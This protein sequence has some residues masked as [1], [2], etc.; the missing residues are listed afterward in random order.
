MGKFCTKC[1]KQLAEDTKFCTSCGMA[2]D[3]SAEQAEQPEQ[4]QQ[5]NTEIGTNTASVQS[6]AA[7]VGSAAQTVKQGANLASKLLQ[8]TST[9]SSISGESAFSVPSFNSGGVMSAISP[10]T[11]LFSGAK[12]I[13]TSFKSAFKDKKKL[14]PAIVLAVTWILL[15]LLPMLGVNPLPVKLA[16]WLTFAQGGV[17]N[18]VLNIIGGVIGKG[19]FATLIVSLFSGGNPLKKI[20]SGFGKLISSFKCS[21]LGQTG[22]LLLGAG[23]ALVAYNFMAGFS[24]L[25][26]SMAGISALLLTLRS[27]GSS[28]GF[29]RKFV[30][31]FTAKKGSPVNTNTVNRVLAGMTTGFAAA[32]MLSAVPWGY[33]PYCVGAAAAVAG[34]ILCIVG[35]NKKE[36]AAA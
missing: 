15:T 7:G 4:T 16:S 6:S 28:G 34:V 32:V 2:I 10:F 25:I 5:V 23:I 11:T 8:T 13:F 9:A 35:G 27:L 1:G 22:A 26:Q 17:S 3:V 30:G 19:V 21:N 36:V 20:K 12:R 29:L 31:G 33:T 24:S 18:N 14:I